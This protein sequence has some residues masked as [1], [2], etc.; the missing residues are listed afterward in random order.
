M[1]AAIGD[2]LGWPM[3][4]RGNRVGGT[5]RVKP[6]PRFVS[7]TRREGGAFGAHEQ[8]IA[9]GTYSDDTQL[10]LAV[11]RSRLR[12]PDWFRHFVEAE[13][14]VW[15]LYER[16][17]GGALKRSARCWSARRAPWNLDQKRE[18][19]EAYFDAGG[20]G[21][22]M[23]C[24]PHVLIDHET[25]RFDQI[26]KYLDADC[27]ST[28]GHPRALV[29]SRVL[30]WGIWWTLSRTSSLEYGE[31]LERTID[32]APEWAETPRPPAE[33]TDAMKD[34]SPRWLEEWDGAVKEML[35][36]LSAARSGLAH[37]AV[38]V[39]SETLAEIGMFGRERGAGTVSAAAAIF[40]ASRYTSQP[41][42]GLLSAAFLRNTDS[43]TVA[44]MTGA[45]LGALAGPDWLGELTRQ[46][47]DS[48]YL[49]EM[50]EWLAT[51]RG[52]E[53]P[54]LEWQ[55]SI[56]TR[57]YRDLEVSAPG[58]RIE[59]PIFGSAAITQIEDHETKSLSNFI[60][61]WSFETELGQSLIIKR[62]DKGKEGT[63]RWRGRY[64]TE[65]SK[66]SD[67]SVAKDRAR[68]TALPR[69]RVGLVREVGDLATSCRFYEGIVGLKRERAT[70]T[71]VS[72]GWLVLELRDDVR[73]GQLS[74]PSEREL[75]E[76]RQSIRIYVDARD[77]DRRHEEVKDF[78]LQ[79]GQLE[80]DP[81]GSRFRCA[82]PDGYVVEF[83]SHGG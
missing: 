45:L 80:R 62:Y 6:A 63:P 60:R 4:D 29:G 66:G 36:Y 53:A 33:W 35:R 20:N 77:I 3:E 34:V 61:S 54:S 27:L 30:S 23:R 9:A 44:S 28:H 50:A 21:A 37:G 11:G 31:L 69:R 32:A 71:T 38:A 81:R 47:Q 75:A 22:A 2:A 40:L 72:F 67:G 26:A 65:K 59:L 24:L 8:S 19:V 83:R 1:A 55:P 79:A 78:G 48:R 15:L 52:P 82:D 43:D 76:S 73:G 18:S 7:W 58:D 64:F 16:G 56:R 74:L 57:L 39:D 46:I 17:G 10:L 12:G 14:P 13:L 41:L 49:E 68:Q 51:G 25:K 42:Q 70:K 5:A